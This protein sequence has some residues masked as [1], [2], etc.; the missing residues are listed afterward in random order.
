M[1]KTYGHL[2]QPVEGI[3]NWPTSQMARPQPPKTLK[4]QG[5]QK[6]EEKGT[7]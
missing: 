2:L 7:T 6:R 3:Q 5:R 1:Q 4:M